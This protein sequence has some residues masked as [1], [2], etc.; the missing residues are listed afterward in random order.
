MI[1]HE[2]GSRGMR[3]WT[4]L[5]L[6]PMQFLAVA[7]V[8]WFHGFQSTPAVVVVVY[9]VIVVGVVVA[10]RLWSDPGPPGGDVVP[11]FPDDPVSASR[12]LTPSPPLAWEGSLPR[13]REREVMAVAVIAIVGSVVEF[14]VSWPLPVLPVGPMIGVMLLLTLLSGRNRPDPGGNALL[15]GDTGLRAGRD[16]PR[17]VGQMEWLGAGV[18]VAVMLLLVLN[19]RMLVDIHHQSHFLM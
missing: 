2:I 17:S 6:A 18:A 15:G 19:T 8:L 12:S 5:V 1:A 10:V 11:S 9:L 14:L 4:P 7:S 3:L 13:T 16:G